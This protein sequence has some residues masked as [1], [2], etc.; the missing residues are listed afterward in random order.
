MKKGDILQDDAVNARILEAFEKEGADAW[1]AE[2]ARER[3]LGNDQDHEPW[4]R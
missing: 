4:R 1:F 3:F 2:G